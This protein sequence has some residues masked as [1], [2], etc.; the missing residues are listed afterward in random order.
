MINILQLRTSFRQQHGTGSYPQVIE[1]RRTVYWFLFSQ[2]LLCGL[3]MS[4]QFSN[5]RNETLI[6]ADE[7]QGKNFWFAL[8]DIKLWIKDHNYLNQF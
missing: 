3:L 5:L 6:A 1:F 4:L 2:V 7:Q 8:L